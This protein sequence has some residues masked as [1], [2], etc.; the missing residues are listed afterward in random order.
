MTNE[1]RLLERAGLRETDRILT[2]LTTEPG[3][4][5]AAL[6]RAAE[7]FEAAVEAAAR[8]V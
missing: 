1:K 3:V 8:T 2:G 5:T 4:L 7:L 6:D